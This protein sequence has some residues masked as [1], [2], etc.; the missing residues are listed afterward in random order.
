MPREKN[1]PKKVRHSSTSSSSDDDVDEKGNIKDLIDYD[2]DDENTDEIVPLL[3]KSKSKKETKKKK[4]K[5]PEELNPDMLARV[6]LMSLCARPTQGTRRSRRVLDDDDEWNPDEEEEE[7]FVFEDTLDDIEHRY[8]KALRKSKRDY[9]TTLHQLLLSE[10]KQEVPLKFRIMNLEYMSDRT[11]MY[12]IRRLNAY[13][14]MD[15]HTGEY[16][17][18][19]NWFYHLEQLPFNTMVGFPIKRKSTKKTIF[20]FLSSTREQLNRTVY[21]HDNV[22]D[23]ILEVVGSLI[24]NQNTQGSIIGLWGPPG[25]GKT[26]I[27]KKGISKVLKRPFSMIGMG[28]AKDS[29]YL[30]GHEYTFEGSKP[31]RIFDVMRDA[32]CMNPVIFLD[33]IDKISD[34]AAGKEISNILCHILDPVQN[35]LFQDRYLGSVPIDLSKVLFVVSFNHIEKIDPVLL[36][37][38]QVIKMEGFKEIHK[39]DIARNYLLPDIYK[40]LNFKETD[41]Y[42]NDDIIR[43]IISRYTNEQGVRDLR[44]HLLSIIRKLNICKLVGAR[45]KKQLNK[46]VS[47]TLS[48]PIQFPAHLKESHVHVLLKKKKVAIP[49]MYL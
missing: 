21:G 46:L 13:N 12:V 17:K 40:E 6:V 16:N 42:I 10:E 15:S 23:K 44:R 2:F 25:I 26:Q 37:R 32:G 35:H 19:R 29:A 11:K 30:C 38:M 28:G 7:E 47:F 43:L 1:E 8:F 4:S 36:D 3:R 39:V 22:K 34:S 18:L 27:V 33:E 45:Y 49:Q 14:Q 20:N 41:L 31:G 9:Y 5:D 48:P 24:S